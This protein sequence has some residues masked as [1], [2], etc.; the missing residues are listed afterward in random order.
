MR[1]VTCLDGVT[2]LCAFYIPRIFHLPEP[3]TSFAKSSPRTAICGLKVIITLLLVF[4]VVQPIVTKNSLESCAVVATNPSGW[5]PPTASTSSMTRSS[6]TKACRT[7]GS[8]TL[9]RAVPQERA[10][11]TAPYPCSCQTL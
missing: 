10:K 9:A 4:M 6:R 7:D 8:V 11:S 5:L 3:N 1:Q 2:I